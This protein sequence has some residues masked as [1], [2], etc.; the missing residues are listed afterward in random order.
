MHSLST[1]KLAMI[2]VVLGL[3][4]GAGAVYVKGSASGNDPAPPMSEMPVASADVEQGSCPATNEQVAA[5]TPLATGEVAAMAPQE[6]PASMAGLAFKAPDGSDVSI[7]DFSGRTLLVNLW[8]TWCAPCREEM[9]ALETLQQT[10]GGEAFEVVTINID[11][12]DDEKPRAFL[13]EIGVE[14]LP[15]YRD[16]SMGVFNDLKRQGFAFGLPVTLLVDETG[17]LLAAMNGPAEWASDDALRLVE[18]AKGI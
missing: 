18:A 8:A 2:A 4:A 5:L 11:T 12:G 1:A 17:C 9:P 13:E 14:H 15:L 10:A 6:E 7:E 16:A 3:V